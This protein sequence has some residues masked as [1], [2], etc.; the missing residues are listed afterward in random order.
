M[1]VDYLWRRGSGRCPSARG[2]GRRL[3]C[4]QVPWCNARSS[5]LS[6]CST[7]SGLSSTNLRFVE[8]LPVVASDAPANHAFFTFTVLAPPHDISI[9]RAVLPRLTL[10]CLLPPAIRA[11][12]RR[13][14]WPFSGQVLLASS[15][16]DCQS[17]THVAAGLDAV[18]GTSLVVNAGLHLVSAEPGH[19]T[20]FP[21][22]L[23]FHRSL[24]PMGFDGL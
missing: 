15:V 18:P 19:S 10:P 6:S 4:S 11:S 14:I 7:A 22:S 21:R 17:F 13:I 2:G 5:R 12:P 23:G 3:L 9:L 20:Q 8:F 16:R 1:E 24:P